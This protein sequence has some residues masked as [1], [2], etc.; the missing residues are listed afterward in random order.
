MRSGPAAAREVQPP[1]MNVGHGADNPGAE[2]ERLRRKYP[3]WRIWR[4]Q[5]TG[6]YWALPPPGHPAVRDLISSTDIAEL[7]RRLDEAEGWAGR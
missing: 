7:A 2:L 5:V 1:A 3:R 4:G 6:E